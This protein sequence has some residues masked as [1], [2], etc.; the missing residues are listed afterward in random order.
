MLALAA[1]QAGFKPLVV[2]LFADQD[3]RDVAEAFHKVTS[4]AVKEISPVIN[5]YV[6]QYN[7]R[8]VVYGS[9]LE[10]VPESLAWLNH[11]FNIMGNSCESF[12][13]VI[14]KKE[15]FRCLRKLDIPF[16]QTQFYKPET[17]G[18][19]LIKP[20]IGKGG[21]GIRKWLV[22][23]H[24]EEQQV[25]VY[26]Q[27]QIE[28]ISMSV[29]FLADGRNVQIIGF[30]QQ[31]T[32]PGSFV[33]SGIIKTQDLSAKLQLQVVHWL[34]KLIPEFNLRGLNSLDFMVD[35]ELCLVLEINPRPPA[36]M[37]LYDAEFKSGLLQEHLNACN[38]RLTF[39]RQASPEIIALQVLYASKDLYISAGFDWPD[40]SM[41]RPVCPCKIYRSQPLCCIIATD[42]NSQ[43]VYQQLRN[44][45]QI[46]IDSIEGK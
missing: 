41:D 26:W 27:R 2:D 37:M 10:A 25:N 1:R 39:D 19:W 29:L 20:G 33:F 44:K 7:V 43:Q 18:Q 42:S 16:P 14:N 11:N 4:L 24:D 21:V 5:R 46:I 36:S 8:D 34:T 45:Q 38:G 23:D 28:G 17:A 13:R 12:H 40:W 30:N 15:F 32:E 22:D 6:D 31:W 3:T 9:G 35:G